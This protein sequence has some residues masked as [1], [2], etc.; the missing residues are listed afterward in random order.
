MHARRHAFQCWAQTGFVTNV[1]ITRI[2]DTS[3]TPK[4]MC[5]AIRIFQAPPRSDTVSSKPYRTYPRAILQVLPVGMHYPEH[6]KIRIGAPEERIFSTGVD[7][8]VLI[9]LDI[10]RKD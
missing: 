1:M 5:F 7:G 9:S 10:F 3:D 6:L 4:F 8:S 2:F